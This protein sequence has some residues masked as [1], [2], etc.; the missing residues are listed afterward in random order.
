MAS[1]S[2]KN[3]QRLADVHRRSPSGD[4]KQFKEFQERTRQDSQV[5]M[6]KERLAVLLRRGCFDEEGLF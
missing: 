2:P 4:Q 6:V 3:K 1:L 5:Q